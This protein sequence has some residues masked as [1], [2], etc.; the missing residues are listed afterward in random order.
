MS[1]IELERS[2]KHYLLSRPELLPSDA[3][4]STADDFDINLAD[5]IDCMTGMSGG[6]WSALYLASRGGQGAS[7]RVLDDPAIVEKYGVIPTGAAEGL[8]VFYREYSAVIFPFATLDP[9]AG[10]PFDITNPQAPGVTTTVFP[11]AEGLETA[12]EAFFGNSTLADVDSSVLAPAVDLISGYTVFFVQNTFRDPPVSSS[13]RLISRA[14]PRS[15]PG[16]SGRFFP[17]FTFNEGKDYYLRDVATGAGS[18]PTLEPAKSI[19][20]V[21][22]DTMEYLLVD[23]VFPFEITSIPAAYFVST[24]AGLFDLQKVAVLSIGSG[25]PTSD[26]SGLSNAGL[27]G[28]LEGFQLTNQFIYS[29]HRALTSLMDYIYY[30]NPAT[31]PYQYLRVTRESPITTEEGMLLNDVFNAGFADPWEA[32]GRSIAEEHRSSIDIFVRDFIFG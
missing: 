16:E 17:D 28:W 22:S 24:E 11:T 26:L 29:G 14:G 4:I 21:G 18:V 31:R 25:L 6:V 3:S 1:L 8:R 15:P 20:P 30:S 23:G 2:I 12:M 7:R 19:S 27:V 10:V 32:I 13:A 9:N 5:Y